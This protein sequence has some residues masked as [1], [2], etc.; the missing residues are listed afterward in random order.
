MN[1]HQGPTHT[2]SSNLGLKIKGEL[3]AWGKKTS[4]HIP[5]TIIL[6]RNET[7]IEHPLNSLLSHWRTT[8]HGSSPLDSNLIEKF[9][10]QLLTPVEVITLFPPTQNHF[11]HN[12]PSTNQNKQTDMSAHSED[13]ELPDSEGELSPSDDESS[14][15]QTQNQ[16]K[17]T[18]SY[19][20]FNT[21][22]RLQVCS[23]GIPREYNQI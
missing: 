19:T 2:S 6:Q 8:L 14:S 13:G 10:S 23:N 4:D 1:H 21:S 7:S 3:W 18:Q 20:L 12:L 22:S 17:E 16:P 5:V 11:E 9:R 15:A